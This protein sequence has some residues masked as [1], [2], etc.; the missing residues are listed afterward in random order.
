MKIAL[1]QP[2]FFPYIGY[3]QLIK[4]VDEFIIFDNAQ[5]IRRSWMNRN[6]ILNE[7]KESAFINVPV[8]KAPRETKIKDIQINNDISWQEKMMANQLSYYKNAPNY[9]FVM[10]FVEECLT[11]EENSLCVLNTKLLMKICSLLDIRTEISILS[12]KFS[13][14]DTASA[15]DEWGVK[16]SIASNASTYINAIGGMEFYN[17]QKYLEKG[18]EIKFLNSKIPTYTQF[19]KNFVPGLSIIDI[20]MF[21]DLA[22]ISRMLDN[23]ELVS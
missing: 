17:Q 18:I 22:S 4:S 11:I 16:T 7:H 19:E 5:Y 9:P 23:Y 13:E 15:A 6:R 20:L 8:I 2:Y 14:I 3:F 21:N 12:K 1:M 10:K